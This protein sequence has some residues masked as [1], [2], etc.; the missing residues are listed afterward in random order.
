MKYLKIYATTP[1]SETQNISMK[2]EAV[3]GLDYYK[4]VLN[5]AKWSEDN[6]YEGTLIYANN[7]LADGWHIAQ[8]ILEHTE[9]LKPLVAVNPIYVRP[10]T[11]AKRVAT[12]AFMYNRRVD[13]NWIAGGFKGDLVS[14]HEDTPHDERYD[15]L[16]DYAKLINGLLTNKGAYT[17]DGKYYKVT[18]VRMR[19]QIS[20]ELIPLELISGTSEAGLAAAKQLG[21]TKV[22]YAKPLSEYEGVS[23]DENFNLGV[24]FGIIARDTSE[25]AWEIANERFP[26]DMKGKMAHTMATKASDSSWHKELSNLEKREGQEVYWLKPFH[27]YKTFCP[28]LVGSHKEVAEELAGY[29]KLGHTS[30]ILDIMNEQDDFTN[31]RIVFEMVEDIL[32]S[33]LSKA[34]S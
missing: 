16:V 27:T 2:K 4:H 22:K 17:H 31:C 13:I 25:Q 3:N 9:K 32:E 26:D 28:Y 30:I 34:I 23:P 19:P 33:V 5:T 11:L 18:N 10:Y 6:G 15:R 29:V 21:A 8:T 7:S 1:E 14:L 24:R 12:L 20:P